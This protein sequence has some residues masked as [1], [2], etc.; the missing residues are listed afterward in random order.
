MSYKLIAL[1]LNFA[2]KELDQD[3]QLIYYQKHHIFDNL[4]YMMNLCYLNFFIHF[5]SQAFG[6]PFILLL[7]QFEPI[8]FAS[9]FDG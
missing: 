8:L 5:D 6:D 3:S 9:N 4:F 7:L 2:F 1:S